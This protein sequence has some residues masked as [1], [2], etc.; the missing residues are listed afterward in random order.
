MKALMIIA[1]A[2]SMV[3]CGYIDRSISGWTGNAAE[4]C[5][6]GIIYLQFTTGSTVKIDRD[7]LAPAKCR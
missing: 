5:H 6:D 2:M 1:L 4:T 7:T 3:S